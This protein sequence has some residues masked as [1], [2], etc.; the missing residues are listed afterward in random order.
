MSGD[1][2]QES[3]GSAEPESTYTYYHTEDG[4]VAVV[5]D[6]K[7]PRAWLRSTVSVPVEA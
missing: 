7:N 3:S 1:A 2:S 6:P 4:L 5:S